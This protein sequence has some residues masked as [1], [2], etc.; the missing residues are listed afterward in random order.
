MKAHPASRPRTWLLQ[1]FDLH[2]TPGQFT[3]GEGATFNWYAAKAV[4]FGVFEGRAA[5]ALAAAKL[6]CPVG[7]C[8]SPAP[9]PQGG[10]Q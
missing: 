3:N 7:A 2:P 10:V 6:L 4:T 8:I 9:E 5:D 1:R